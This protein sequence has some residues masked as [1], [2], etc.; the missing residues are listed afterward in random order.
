MFKRYLILISILIF[1]ACAGSKTTVTETKQKVDTVT[2]V[3][4]RK[5]DT[6]IVIPKDSVSLFIPIKE[7]KLENK[8]EPK[9]FT[10]KSGRSKVTVKIDSSGIKAISNCDSIAQRLDYYEKTFKQ[11]RRESLDTKTQ[12]KEKKGYSKLEL[13]LHMIAT[14]VVSFAAAY[15]IKTFKL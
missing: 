7:L 6:L 12:I 10:Q 4:E 11:I 15:L 3:T 1:T 8:T 9:V 13:I 14:A 5:L 2:E